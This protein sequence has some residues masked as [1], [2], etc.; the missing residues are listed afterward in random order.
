MEDK[1][2][3]MWRPATLVGG[4]TIAVQFFYFIYPTP[5]EYTHKA[6]SIFRVNRFTGVA[7]TATSEGWKTDTQI[8]KER[9][10]DQERVA[11]EIT[12]AAARDAEAK[13]KSDAELA[14]VKELDEYDLGGTKVNCSISFS[15]SKIRFRLTLSQSGGAKKALDGSYVSAYYLNA[16]FI[17][18]QSFPVVDKE[19]R[20]NEFTRVIDE[21]NRVTAHQYEGQTFITVEDYRRIVGWNPT[22]NWQY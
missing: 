3:N 8:A 4:F 10:L 19:V 12:D 1:H 14:K 13:A 17:D 9:E 11:A 22:Y 5:Y 7:E 16:K 18:D 6:P 15:G 21:K 20:L 2:R